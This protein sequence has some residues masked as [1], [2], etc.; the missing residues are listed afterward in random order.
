MMKVYFTYKRKLFLV[1]FLES[2]P[3]TSDLPV[4]LFSDT[5]TTKKNKTN[6]KHYTNLERTKK[7]LMKLTIVDAMPTAN[8]AIL[9]GRLITAFLTNARVSDRSSYVAEISF[10]VDKV[11]S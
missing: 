6:N 3:C 4:K 5:L 7:N 9:T 1:Y 10:S 11:Y 8:L 2:E